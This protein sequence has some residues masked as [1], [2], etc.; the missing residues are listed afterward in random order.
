M[1]IQEFFE[2]IEGK[3]DWLIEKWESFKK[4]LS[5]I[6]KGEEN[7]EKTEVAAVSNASDWSTMPTELAGIQPPKPTPADGVSSQAAAAGN[8]TNNETTNNVQQQDSRS[9][10]FNFSGAPNDADGFF[11]AVKGPLSKNPGWM[12]QSASTMQFG[13]AS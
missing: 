9:F 11:K 13:G 12:P 4:S 3:I 1:Q 8:V 10:V 7:R 5:E 2:W 6:A